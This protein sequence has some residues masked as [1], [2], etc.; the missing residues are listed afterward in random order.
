MSLPLIPHTPGI[1]QITTYF[2]KFSPHTTVYKTRL[3]K[4]NYTA[5]KILMKSTHPHIEYLSRPI[6]YLMETPPG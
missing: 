4:S 1:T 2:S 3:D 5:N 6:G